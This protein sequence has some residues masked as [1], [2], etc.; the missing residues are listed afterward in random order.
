MSPFGTRHFLVFMSQE[1][2]KT[3]VCI[4]DFIKRLHGRTSKESLR[5]KRWIEIDETEN[6][7]QTSCMNSLEWKRCKFRRSILSCNSDSIRKAMQQ[8]EDDKYIGEAFKSGEPIRKKS[9]DYFISTPTVF[10]KKSRY[11][12]HSHLQR[13]GNQCCVKE[14]EEIK[15]EYDADESNPKERKVL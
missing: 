7:T 8:S 13:V 1:V 14:F 11:V 15:Q 2:E 9:L 3:D 5:S 4:P 6:K 12:I 10:L